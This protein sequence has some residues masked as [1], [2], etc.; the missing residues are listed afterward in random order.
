MQSL[1]I[2]RKIGKM[3]YQKFPRVSPNL[4]R[5]GNIW[6]NKLPKSPQTEGETIIFYNLKMTQQ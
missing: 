1:A 5:W 2:Q 6:G 4:L 3:F